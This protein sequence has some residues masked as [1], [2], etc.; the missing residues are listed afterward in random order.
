VERRA[1]SRRVLGT[2]PQL[3]E[4]VLG[5]PFPGKGCSLQAESSQVSD[6]TILHALRQFVV[7]KIERIR[8][9]PVKMVFMQTIKGL[10]A[11]LLAAGAVFATAGMNNIKSQFRHAARLHSPA[12]SEMAGKTAVN[13]T[14]S[15]KSGETATHNTGKIANMETKTDDQ[16]RQN[17]P[18]T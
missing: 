3:A 1:P 7:T 2:K 11:L 12:L 13:V 14:G 10:T 17:I 6:G 9:R 18:E 8:L 15:V 16:T 5:A 4:T